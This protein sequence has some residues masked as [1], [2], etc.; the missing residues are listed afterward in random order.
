MMRT[1]S[2]FGL[3]GTVSL[4]GCGGAPAPSAPA[5]P[6]SPP[7][8]SSPSP[9]SPSATS[10]RAVARLAPTA[11][12]GVGGEL[13]FFVE[14]G[15]VRVAGSVTGLRPGSEH[16]FHVHEKGDCS[17]PDASSA[18]GHFNPEGHVH[19]RQG[20]DQHHLGDMNNLVANERGEASVEFF[21]A[22]GE[23]GSGSERD[24]LGRGV[25][26]HAER[27]DYTSQPAGNAGPRIACG[28]IALLE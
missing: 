6:A 28:A 11:G 21:V 7:S 27:D 8:E 24:L 23:L 19:G 17:A 12:S 5:S 13:R 9:S 26:V 1:R 15:G 16:G 22:R 4:L 3:L 14:E 18:G 20:T 25:I 10:P 2:W